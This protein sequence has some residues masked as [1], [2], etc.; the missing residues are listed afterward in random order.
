[1]WLGSWAC[2]RSTV[3]TTGRSRGRRNPFR[4]CWRR[5]PCTV[6]RS[7]E[8]RRS[9]GQWGSCTSGVDGAS[10]AAAA[11]APSPGR[12]VGSGTSSCTLFRLPFL[13]GDFGSFLNCVRGTASLR[14]NRCCRRPHCRPSHCLL[15]S[16]CRRSRNRCQ[17]HPIRPSCHRCQPPCTRAVPCTDCRGH[18][19]EAS[20]RTPFSPAIRSCTAAW[21]V[22]I[23]SGL[24]R[25]HSGKR[26]AACGNPPGRWACTCCTGRTWGPASIWSP[27]GARTGAPPGPLRPGS[28]GSFR[29]G[30][31]SCCSQCPDTLVWWSP[32]IADWDPWV[33]LALRNRVRDSRPGRDHPCPFRPCRD[34]HCAAVH[35]LDKMSAG[36][37]VPGSGPSVDCVSFCAS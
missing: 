24:S 18:H 11:A 34:P 4:R 23:P 3:P 15:A 21:W 13:L 19:E 9:F 20:A 31:M 1:M 33:W 14:W 35:P 6:C 7:L 37:R 29:W 32:R 26:A 27:P 2:C 8:R 5:A 22:R 10:W 28:R 17:S 25:R 30:R 12:W 16:V 36:G